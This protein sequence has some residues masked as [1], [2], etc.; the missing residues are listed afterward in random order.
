MRL[1]DLNN[2]QY[3][4]FLGKS[5]VYQVVNIRYKIDYWENY[6][7]TYQTKGSINF[8]KWCSNQKDKNV[9]LFDY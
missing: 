9:F 8:Y 4:S 1:S 7:I 6:E 3:F 5:I 2:G